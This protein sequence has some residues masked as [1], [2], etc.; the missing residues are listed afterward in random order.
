MTKTRGLPFVPKQD[1]PKP[2][3]ASLLEQLA[4]LRLITD[5]MLALVSHMD[6][7][8]R[9]QFVNKADTQ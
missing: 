2:D 6:K 9:Y 4:Q 5:R 3:E 1:D 7:D 8:C